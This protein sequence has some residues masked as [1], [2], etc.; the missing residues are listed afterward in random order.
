MKKYIFLLAALVMLITSCK[1]ALEVGPRGSLN[2]NQVATPSQAEGFVTAAYS[3]LGNDEINRALSMYQYGNIR[4]DDAYKGG[5]GIAHGVSS[6]DAV[7]LLTS[8]QYCDA[9]PPPTF[10]PTGPR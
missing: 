3:Q 5:G 1:K 7:Q 8:C 9:L 4:A 10:V 2:E 6:P